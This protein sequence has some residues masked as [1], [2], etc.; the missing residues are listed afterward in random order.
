MRVKREKLSVCEKECE[1]KKECVLEAREKECE[2]VFLCVCER[3]S[4]CF[5]VLETKSVMRDNVFFLCVRKRQK[6]LVWY[7][8]TLKAYTSRICYKASPQRYTGIMRK[9][10]KGTHLF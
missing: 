10:R 7:N 1:Y 8:H 2:R 9:L 5:C 6:A 3:V 4:E